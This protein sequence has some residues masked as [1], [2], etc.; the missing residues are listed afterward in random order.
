MSPTQLETKPWVR[1]S[2]RRACIPLGSVQEDGVTQVLAEANA[3]TFWKK[4]F[5]PMLDLRILQTKMSQMRVQKSKISN[6]TR[7]QATRNES[8][9]K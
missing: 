8:H 5:M 9:Q 6:P 7:K 2:I 1:G 3:D 4:A